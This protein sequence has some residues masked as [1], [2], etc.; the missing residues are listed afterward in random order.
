M[1]KSQKINVIYAN[2]NKPINLAALAAVIADK[3]RNE[4]NKH[5]KK[6]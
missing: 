6:V 1:T 2:T 5:G 3:I 4:G